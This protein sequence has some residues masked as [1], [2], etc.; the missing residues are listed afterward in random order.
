[1]HTMLHTLRITASLM[2]IAAAPSVLALSAAPQSGQA[3]VLF[4]PALEPGDV[5]AQV[6][7]AGAELV[8]FGGAPGLVVVK[9]PSD[10]PHALRQ[11]GAWLVLDPVVMGG[12]APT[13]STAPQQ[14]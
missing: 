5:L 2:A 3:A 14:G 4:N 9:L 6:S 8:R 7:R 13:P 12:C 1:M 10:G 11:A